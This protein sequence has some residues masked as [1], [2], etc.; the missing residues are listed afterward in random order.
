MKDISY[1]RSIAN[2]GNQEEATMLIPPHAAPD[3]PVWWRANGDWLLDTLEG[4]WLVGEHLKVWSQVRQRWL[5][6][7]AWIWR[8]Y[9]SVVK[10]THWLKQSELLPLLFTEH[11][12]LYYQKYKLNKWMYYSCFL[13]CFCFVLF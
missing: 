1:S 12:L 11:R 4:L 7:C 13:V 2:H 3:W 10:I 9:V 6:V 5:S 8:P